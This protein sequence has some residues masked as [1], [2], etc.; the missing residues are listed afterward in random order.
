MP[1]EGTVEVEVGVAALED[2]EIVEEPR[3]TPSG[4]EKQQENA[5]YT[6]LVNKDFQG[7]VMECP[8]EEGTQLVIIHGVRPTSMST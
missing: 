8:G 3:P 4:K 6:T 1:I 7:F 2:M 5:A